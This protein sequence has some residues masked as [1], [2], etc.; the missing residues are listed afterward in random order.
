MNIIILGA[1]KVGEAVTGDLSKEFHD[2]TLIE[3]DEKRF[4][5][6]MN[7]YDIKGVLGNGASLEILE[8]AGVE[9]CDV[10][11]AITR[12]DELNMIACVIAKNLGADHTIARV[13]NPEYDSLSKIMSSSLSRTPFFNPEKQSARVA[14]ELIDFPMAESIESF[15][16]H[17]A[18]IVEM[19]VKKDFP[20]KGKSLIE[21]RKTYPDLIICFVIHGDNTFIPQGDYVIQE[22]DH[23]FATGPFPQQEEIFRDNGQSERKIK[24]I[25]IVGGGLLGEYTLKLFS[26]DHIKIK[27]IERDEAR[28]KELS[29]RFPHAQ[30][31]HGDGTD[32]EFLD[33]QGMPNYDAV[34]AFTGIDEENIFISFKALKDGVP[35][36]L[37]KINRT[38]LLSVIDTDKLQSIIT[39]KRIAADSIVQYVRAIY[40]SKGSNVEALY[41]LADGKI[42][43]LQFIAKKGSKIVGQQITNLA[44]RENIIVAYM[45]RKN[46]VIFPTG[47]DVIQVGDRVVIIAT[48]EKH[49]TDLD[50]IVK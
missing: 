7:L 10:F 36:T 41:T 12:N 37:T 42:E 30:I 49:L 9:N 6:M 8:E 21:F 44:L 46:K 18:T 3:Q 14:L 22:G 47:Q 45:Y 19:I 48:E 24:S 38:E 28:A 16:N 11:I 1:G 20:L 31:I 2:I 13:R 15:A 39:P 26:R 34:L 40:N 35:K 43:A 5:H 25:F 32:L 17:R 4:E 33:E 29:I 50:E 23:I 27:V